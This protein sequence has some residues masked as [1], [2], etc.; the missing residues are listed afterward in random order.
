MR[1]KRYGYG[2]W[3][4]RPAG[5]H[6]NSPRETLK[7]FPR[8]ILGGG[9]AHQCGPTSGYSL[10][11]SPT[12]P[13]NTKD[14]ALKSGSIALMDFLCSSFIGFEKRKYLT[15]IH[16]KTSNEHIIS[17]F[18]CTDTLVYVIFFKF[19]SLFVHFI[20]LLLFSFI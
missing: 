1:V 3:I 15:C 5:T 2:P 13:L 11:L 7:T 14:T 8:H 4:N 20:L 12:R 16:G 18:I 10:T 17:C 9:W 19:Y 6:L